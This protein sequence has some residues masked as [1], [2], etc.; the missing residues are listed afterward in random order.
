MKVVFSKNCMAI[1]TRFVMSS[2]KVQKFT[3]KMFSTVGNAVDSLLPDIFSAK[4]ASD[5]WAKRLAE[6]EER[7]GK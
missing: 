4:K 1:I 3:D 5:E 6:I 7:I 2:K